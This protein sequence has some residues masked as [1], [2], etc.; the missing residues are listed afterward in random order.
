MSTGREPG[1]PAREA[2]KLGCGCLFIVLLFVGVASFLAIA[3]EADFPGAETLRTAGSGGEEVFQQARQSF[4]GSDAPEESQPSSSSGASQAASSAT[5]QSTTAAEAR[6]QSLTQ[7]HIDYKLYM[8]ELVNEERRKAGVPPVSLGDNIAAQLH[9]EASLEH[10]ISGHWGV[11]GLKP[12]MRYS[13]AGGYQANAENA[14]G[15]RY[16]I[17]A[18]DRITPVGDIRE[19]IRES[20]EGW[21]NSPYHRP[22]VLDKWNRKV[23]VGLAWDEYNFKAIQHFEGVY[24]SFEEPPEISNGTLSVSGRARNGLQFSRREQL[25][26][27]VYYDP[28]PRTLTVGQVAQTFCYDPG[29]QVAGFRFSLT[30]I[31]LTDFRLRNIDLRD[32]GLGEVDLSDIDLSNA[33]LSSIDLDNIGL[34][35]VDFWDQKEFTTSYSPCPDPYDVAPEAPA[36]GSQ[37]EA[38]RSWEQAYEAS[39]GRVPQVITVPW[40]TA[41]QWVARGT[42]FSIEADVGELLT[43][44]GP[45]VYTVLLWGVIGG[46]DVPF[47]R[48]SIFHRIEPP[49]T[50]RQ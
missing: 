6:R 11:D 3:K 26:L 9:A 42:E 44:H 47:S 12:Y 10:C 29:I 45:G 39:D 13:L 4:E 43:K 18:S 34:S 28:P 27:Q 37:E 25:G 38:V 15:L 14:S 46:E 48:Y 21:M 36:P 8:L 31:D 16:C 17:T 7:K 30:E 23:N 40:I 41:N 19:E 50:Y 35:D 5:A 33:G 24:V 22:T 1:K 2:G 20:M 49:A 32:V